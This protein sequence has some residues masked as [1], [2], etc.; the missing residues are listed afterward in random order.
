MHR[1]IFNIVLAHGTEG[2]QPDVER[3]EGGPYPHLAEPEQEF[4]GEMEAGGG[5][6]RRPGHTC[7]DGL[8]ALGILQGGVDVGR[9]RRDAHLPGQRER[10]LGEGQGAFPALPFLDYLGLRADG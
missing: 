3:D 1:V 6:R 4:R 5:G 2:V 8:V 9:Q 7:V 10:R